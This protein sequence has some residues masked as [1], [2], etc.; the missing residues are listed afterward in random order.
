M[1]KDGTESS[2]ECT[3]EDSGCLNPK[4]FDSLKLCA[5]EPEEDSPKSRVET[6]L[7]RTE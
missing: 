3:K 5:V 6:N 7:M 4:S 1:C 2:T